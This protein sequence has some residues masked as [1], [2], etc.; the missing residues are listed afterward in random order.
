MVEH[1]RQRRRQ[2]LSAAGVA[3]LIAANML[4]ASFA[5]SASAAT[6][7][8]RLWVT[9]YDGPAKTGDTAYAVAVSPDGTKV[10]VTGISDFIPGDYGTV[11]YES[12][13]GTRLWVSRYDGPANG[14]DL[15]LDVAVSPDGSKV[16]V[17]GASETR[18]G[19]GWATIAYDS[20]TGATEWIRRHKG[21]SP[22]L[23]VSPDGTKVFV[24]G[25]APS[26]TGDTDYAT[27]AYS[28]ATGATLWAR[29][30]DGPAHL[31][32][33]PYA[34]FATPDAVVVTGRSSGS[35]ATYV[36]YATVAYDPSTGSRLWSRRY[37]GPGHSYDAAAAVTGSADGSKVFV[38]GASTE[39]NGSTA[40]YA[41]I[42]YDGASGKKVWIRRYRTPSGSY[43][44]FATAT[45]DGSVVFV[46]G[47]SQ[48][49]SGEDYATVAY[50]GAT[51]TRLWV[52]RQ[53][54]PGSRL[55]GPNGIAA[56]PD[57]TTVYVTGFISN[58]PLSG[59]DFGTFAYRASTG[60]LLWSRFFSSAGRQLDEAWSVAASPDGSKVFVAGEV[61][62]FPADYATIA[63]AA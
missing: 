8:T 17:T 62:G 49:F 55:D 20:S 31:D 4:V 11:A 6:S 48:A 58:G 38:T 57:G 32:D 24:T 26:P 12:A 61:G 13:T 29:R 7:G 30:Y 33:V 42:A 46:T 23:A 43:A 63:Y 34:V 41:T 9:R 60:A 36:D 59:E 54:G 21:S 5:T 35:N 56:S 10:F 53:S 2:G 47:Q 51:G 28:S 50:D 37:D 1:R 22:T 39:T 14:I 45:A 19:F 25:W 52:A 40:D 18:H 15:A 27:L 3:S 44:E 16:F